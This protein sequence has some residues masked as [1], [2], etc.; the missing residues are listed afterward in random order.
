[1]QTH[2]VLIA[3]LIVAYFYWRHAQQ[4]KETA[5]AAVRRQCQR[6]EVQMLDDY[7]ALN[8]CSLRRDGTGKIRILRRF[9]FEFSA[10]GLDRYGGICVML[11]DEVIKIQLA[12][13]HFPDQ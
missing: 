4:V 3:L 9:T 1:M 5:L 11:G 7:I 10:T 12:A 13:H 2:L 8:H 6:E